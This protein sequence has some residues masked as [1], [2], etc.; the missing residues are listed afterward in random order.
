MPRDGGGFI[1]CGV[2]TGC[3]VVHSLVALDLD[4][5]HKLPNQGEMTAVIDIV[6]LTLL[7]SETLC[8]F[9]LLWVIIFPPLYFGIV[10]LV[11]LGRAYYFSKRENRMFGN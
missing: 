1:Q 11:S 2:D 9:I 6:H 5:S 7:I 8:L 4:S 10:Y 3:N